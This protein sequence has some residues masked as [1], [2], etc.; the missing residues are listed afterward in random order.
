MSIESTRKKKAAAKKQKAKNK[1]NFESSQ[2]KQNKQEMLENALEKN[3]FGTVDDP[4]FPSIKK[5]VRVRELNLNE[6]EL[7]HKFSNEF[8]DNAFKTIQKYTERNDYIRK[9]AYNKSSIFDIDMLEIILTEKEFEEFFMWQNDYARDMINHLVDLLEYSKNKGYKNIIEKVEKSFKKNIDTKKMDLGIMQS[10]KLKYIL[11]YIQMRYVDLAPFIAYDFNMK[12]DTHENRIK[13]FIKYNEVSKNT[14]HGLQ[15][16]FLN[17][18]SDEHNLTNEAIQDRVKTISNFYTKSDIKRKEVN[19]KAEIEKE[20]EEILKEIE[21]IE[22]IGTSF[23]AS[24][25]TF[26]Y[27]KAVTYSKNSK[28][29]VEKIL[30]IEKENQLKIYSL[31]NSILDLKI[32]EVIRKVIENE[33]KLK[34]NTDKAY[35]EVENIYNKYLNPFYIYCIKNDLDFTD[36]KDFRKVNSKFLKKVS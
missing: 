24:N 10:S 22:L 11:R 26:E 17:K 3:F 34:E 8:L 7:L 14:N 21:K 20:H 31:I 33:V 25:N 12:I 4:K 15:R 36:K 1:L 9:Y 23:L 19:V 27:D 32:L 30:K 5:I 16:K 2:L 35:A 29:S 13:T 18:I 6:E 28:D